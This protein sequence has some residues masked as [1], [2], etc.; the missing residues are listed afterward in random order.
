MLF[1]VDVAMAFSVGLCSLL[2][3]SVAVVGQVSCPFSGD[4]DPSM[5]VVIMKS[6]VVAFVVVFVA[7]ETFA[8]RKLS[9]VFE[10]CV[11]LSV[12]AS[13]RPSSTGSVLA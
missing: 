9:E 3:P 10:T 2:V 8:Y 6:G 13:D 4:D 1:V 5:R 12:V 11:P 7:L